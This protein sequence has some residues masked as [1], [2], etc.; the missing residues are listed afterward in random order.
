VYSGRNGFAL[1]GTA[2][3]ATKEEIEWVN[4]CIEQGKYIKRII[5]QKA[6]QFET[7][8]WYKVVSGKGILKDK[9]YIKSPFL[10]DNVI[11][12]K[13]YIGGCGSTYY[14]KTG[15]SFGWA[16]PGYY[17]FVL[18]NDLSEIQQ[19]LPEGH[20]D[21]ITIE[22]VVGNYYVAFTTGNIFR[23]GPN[24]NADY[25]FGSRGHGYSNEAFHKN[26]GGFDKKD[27]RLAT[28]EEKQWL[29][30]CIKANKF[31]SSIRM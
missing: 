7:G 2:R 25:Y 10:E 21:K 31:R 3:P 1:K 27:A 22:L 24:N 19:Y 17:T 16:E 9:Y 15:D 8:K 11:R 20:V 18:M 14:Q 26:G 13:E 6:A 28:P 5:P 29:E 23:W 4:C 12:S 30:A